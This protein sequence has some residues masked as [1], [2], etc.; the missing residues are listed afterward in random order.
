MSTMN[1]HVRRLRTCP[2]TTVLLSLAGAMRVPCERVTPHL[3]GCI[4]ELRISDPPFNRFTSKDPS[5]A[6]GAPTRSPQEIGHSYAVC[7][8][9]RADLKPN[10]CYR[11]LSDRMRTTI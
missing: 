7:S 10:P 5:G 1:S 2:L 3:L 4:D 8:V 9:R 6:N 11:S